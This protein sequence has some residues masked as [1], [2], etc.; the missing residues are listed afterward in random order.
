[1]GLSSG[2]VWWETRGMGSG[3]APLIDLRKE[4]Q[5]GRWVSKRAHSKGD[6]EAARRKQALP[7]PNC[8]GVRDPGQI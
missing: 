1:V 5:W 2:S 6:H 3:L 4:V 8:R 7:D